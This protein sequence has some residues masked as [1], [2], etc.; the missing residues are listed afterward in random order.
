M[1]TDTEIRLRATF[2]A[3]EAATVLPTR[4]PLTELLAH[5]STGTTTEDPRRG[6]SWLRRHR[7]LTVAALA[8][9]VLATGGS[10]YA[11]RLISSTPPASNGLFCYS[12]V[13]SDQSDNAP[14][15]GVT[16]AAPTL[17]AGTTVGDGMISEPVALCADLYRQGVLKL[18]VAHLSVP[19]TL[20]TDD[21]V[22]RL[23][24][25]VRGDGTVAVEPAGPA[26]CAT[27]GM[28]VFTHYLPASP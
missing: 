19:P 2:A 24:A 8:A 22:P 9:A 7:R 15:T 1:T 12:V 18:G 23:T 5:P 3:V 11:V 17:A 25:C 6:R 14:G 26:V 16:V 4:L 21:P 13:S 10:A 27:I 20:A 28:T